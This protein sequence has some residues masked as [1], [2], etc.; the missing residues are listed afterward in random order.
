MYNRQNNERIEK[1]TSDET[2]MQTAMLLYYIYIY[3]CNH[4]ERYTMYRSPKV[5]VNTPFNI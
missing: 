1:Q 4:L 2:L 3:K 5:V